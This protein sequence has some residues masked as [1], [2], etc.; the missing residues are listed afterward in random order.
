V[1]IDDGASGPQGTNPTG[2]ID[3]HVTAV[4]D[5]PTATNLTQSLTISEDAAATTL[6]TLAPVVSDVDSTNVTATLTL[7]AAAGVL[8]GAGAGVLNS[9]TLTYTITGTQAA[10]NS[11]LAAVTYDSADNFNGTT[12]VG[13]TIDDG[14]SGPQGTNPTGTV[15]IHVTAVNDAPTLTATGNNPN[16]VPGGVDLFSG[17]TASTGPA[18]ESTQVLQKLVLTV[19][20]V[21]GTAS[22]FLTIDGTEVDLTDTNAVT[23]LGALGVHA[24]VS[25]AGSTATVTLTSAGL[26]DAD[27]QTLVDGLK[28]TDTN[29]NPGDPARVV[30]LTSVQDNGGTSPGV[31]TATLNITS[32]VN[33]DVAPTITAGG[34]LNY[35]ENATS[36]ID[37]TITITDPDNANMASA[38]VTIT[39][40]FNS[41]Q[42]VLSFTPV[43]TITGSYDTATGVLTLSGNDT[44]ANYELALESITY[45]NTSDDPTTTQRTVTY[46]VNDGFEDS[47]PGTATINVTAVNDEPVLTA[48]ALNPSFTENGSAV[49]LFSGA[50]ASAVEAAQS[51]DQL[52][53]NV[54][55]VAGTGATED[56]TIDGTVI[57]LTNGNT[58]TTTTNGMS[59]TV[60]L[61]A[62]T[63]TVTV[64]KVGGIS[65]TAMNTLVDNLA[66]SNTSDDP[67]NASRVVTITSLRDTGPNGGVNNDD[68]IHSGLT[69]QSTVAV[70][71]VNDEPTLT[72]TANGGGAVTFIEDSSPGV[73]GSGPVDL[74]STPHTSTVESG[75]TITQVVLTVTNVVD[76]TEYLNIGGT[77][78]ELTN[79]SEAITVGGAA[80][81]ATVSVTAGTAT[82]TVTPSTTFSA[83]NIDSLVDSLAYNNDD[84]TPTAT[85]H[86]IS[87]TSLTDSGS[88]IAP[89]DNTGSPSVSTI[90]T[91]QPTNDAPTAQ[92]FNFTGNAA[93]DA[94]GNTSLV[95]DDTTVAGAP[96]PAG[97]QK[98]ING[99]LLTGATDPDGPN[100]LATVAVTNVA[101]AHGHVT[102]NTVGVLPSVIV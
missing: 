59:V 93:N 25:L 31:D 74:F 89:N 48:T 33:F 86:T 7:D 49:G 73:V 47:A 24:S 97:P 35:I 81:T 52:V 95:L 68:N 94:I 28:Y 13:V 5:A 29:V 23:T 42:D 84:N 4:N 46:T 80:G 14:A 6:F 16:Y 70:T 36:Q 71:P 75:Q 62:G 82:I 56:L 43:G 79:H 78:V 69:V 102:I 34:T 38:K 58:Q 101:T 27:M 98:T 15:D 60:A 51:L 44:K 90:V 20:N 22:D 91:V 100:A 50:A 87:V 17:V 54:T 19:T 55:N 85:T 40:G 39:T 2:T 67:G 11:A 61:A 3:I 8:N 21:S 63:A 1:T 88:N 18:D 77:P 92:D 53:L 64:S 83:A 32:T 45:H 57:A 10:V 30:T 65:S 99:S 12:N 37:N 9:G 76:T 96:D 72:A 66:Y 26:S 41:A